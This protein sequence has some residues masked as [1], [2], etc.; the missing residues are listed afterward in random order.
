MQKNITVLNGGPSTCGA[1]NINPEIK[2][3]YYKTKNL[4]LVIKNNTIDV[5]SNNQIITDNFVTKTVLNRYAKHEHFCGILLEYA[6]FKKSSIINPATLYF[7]GYPD[8][9]AQLPRMAQCGINVPDTILLEKHAIENNISTI[10]KD[11]TYPLVLK[12]DGE[13]GDNVHLCHNREEVYSTTSQW[14]NDEV[15]TLQEYIPNTYD[16]RIV[17]V[18]N[19][20]IGAIKRENDTSFL[21]NVAKGGTVKAYTPTNLEKELAITSLEVNKFD[22]GGVD[23]IYDEHLQ[24]A[25]IE[26]NYGLGVKGFESI[27]TTNRLF[28]EI[29]KYL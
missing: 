29:G 9:C 16:I 1:L 26:V 17:A 4:A 21:N 3:I 13:C 18:K 8:K 2:A 28:T 25:V 6:A 23:I 20:V 12:K 5:I 10:E 11:I 7:K 19:N 14:K 22:F 27:H 15:V 24:P